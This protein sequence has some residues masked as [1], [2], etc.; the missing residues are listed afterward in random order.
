MNFKVQFYWWDIFIESFYFG[1]SSSEIV[2][3]VKT[4]IKLCIR[5]SKKGKYCKNKIKSI[6]NSVNLFRPSFKSPQLRSW[7]HFHVS[8]SINFHNYT[9][10]IK[11][12]L[13]IYISRSVYI[14]AWS[15]AGCSRV[16]DSPRLMRQRTRSNRIIEFFI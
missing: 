3:K 13:K 4:F 15:A 14:D 2:G 7:F 1:P 12:K 10:C 9:H 6:S 16:W 11:I 5:L 8:L